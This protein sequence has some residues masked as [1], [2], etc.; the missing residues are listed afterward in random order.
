MRRFLGI[1]V[2]LLFCPGGAAPLAAGVIKDGAGRETVPERPFCRIIS[3]YPAHTENLASLGAATNVIGI[4]AA[5]DYPPVLL[6]RPRF[7][8]REDPEKFIAARPDLVLVRPMI[9]RAYPR[10]LARLRQA[11]IRVV[12]LQP[13]SM[14]GIFDYWRTLG[15]L[16]GRNREAEGMIA[17]FQKSLAEIRKK[18]GAIPPEK[19]VRVYFEAIHSKMKT[20]AP[21]S[22]AHFVLEEAGGINVACDAARVRNTNIAAYGKERILARA[23]Q[24][25]LFLAQQGRMNPVSRDIISAEPGFQ[26]IEAVAEGRIFLIEEALVSRPTLRILEGIERLQRILYP[27]PRAAGN[28]QGDHHDH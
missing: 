24:I 12:S 16:T 19:R 18:T 7:S 11:G 13:T 17:S 23:G 9:E 5:D 22:I 26:A 15:L 3:L 28:R 21:R 1:L 20:F 14:A 25:D 8:Y 4:S 27:D 6:D 10:L 2:L